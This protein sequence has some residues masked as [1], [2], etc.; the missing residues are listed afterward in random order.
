LQDLERTRQL[1]RRL[2][3]MGAKV[4]LDDFG[5]GYTSFSYLK[6]LPADIIKIDGILVRDML[7]TDANIAIVGSIVE[8]AHNLGMECI[9][10]WVEDLATLEALARMGV[11][12][13]QGHVFSAARP[14]SEILASDTVLPLIQDAGARQFL[15]RQVGGTN[16]H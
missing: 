9:A 10:E 16:A 11:D 4:A 15:A 14:P 2:Q 13:V 5:A 8:L 7:K 1:M 3:R 6:E 12:Q